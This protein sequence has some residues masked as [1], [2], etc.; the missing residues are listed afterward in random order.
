MSTPVDNCRF[1]PTAAGLADWTVDQA[2]IGYQDDLEAE[3]VDGQPYHVRA[4]NSDGTK[5]EIA[6]GVY[7]QATRTF[8]RTTIEDSS[9]GGT[10]VDFDTIPECGLVLLA[11][12]LVGMG[13]SNIFVD[14]GPPPA[15]GVVGQQILVGS[16]A[17]A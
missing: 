15:G 11:Q 12:D 4:E 5:W 2:V 6:T 3:A 9:D 8:A 13:G 16:G 1:V 7:D 14:D 17:P 10:K